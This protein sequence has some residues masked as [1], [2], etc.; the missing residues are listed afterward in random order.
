MTK[1]IL[2]G[3][4][5]F[6]NWDLFGIWCLILGVFTRLTSNYPPAKPGALRLLAPQRGLIAIGKEQENLSPMDRTGI[7]LSPQTR[8]RDRNAYSR[9]CQ[10]L[11]VPRQSRGFTHD[12]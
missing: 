9:K 11:G 6:G 8:I 3:I 10:T 1:M 12:Y 4:S 7:A 2:F 5:D